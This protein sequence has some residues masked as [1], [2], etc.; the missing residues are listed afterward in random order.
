MLLVPVRFWD[1]IRP[2]VDRV[3]MDFI[4]V[5]LSKPVSRA[6]VETDGSHRPLVELW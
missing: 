3:S 4:T 1:R 5:F 6:M 2:E